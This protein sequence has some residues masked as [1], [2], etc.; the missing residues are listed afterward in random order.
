MERGHTVIGRIVKTLSATVVRS[1][2]SVGAINGNPINNF[3]FGSVS[4][5]GRKGSIRLN[6]RRTN[7][8]LALN[9]PS[10]M[11]L[12]SDALGAINLLASSVPKTTCR[13]LTPYT[14]NPE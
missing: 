9:R 13:V 3:Q 4:S 8:V 14:K 7:I 5:D 11:S 2:M 12:K 10:L 1:K 6:I